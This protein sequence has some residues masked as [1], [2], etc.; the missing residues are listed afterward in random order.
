MKNK[1]LKGAFLFYVLFSSFCA[2]AQNY[3]WQWALNGGGS[4]GSGGWSYSVEQVYDIAVDTDNNYYFVA[5]IGNGSPKL[6]GSAV[7]VYNS[8]GGN[9][10]SDIFLFSTTCDGTVRWKQAIGGGA[11]DRSFKITLDNN[12]G[13]YLSARV[14]NIV[15][16]GQNVHFSPDVQMI[17]VPPYNP[18]DPQ[19]TQPSDAYKTAFVLKYNKSNGHYVQ[20]ADI[21]GNVGLPNRNA[22]ILDVAIDSSNTLHLIVGLLNGTHLNGQVTVPAGFTNTYQYYAVKYDADLNYTGSMLLPVTGSFVEPS[23]SFTYDEVKNRYYVA[24]FRSYVNVDENIPLSYN[25]VSINS[26]AYVLALN[27]ANGNEVWRREIEGTG[28]ANDI[29]IYDLELDDNG[30]VYIG[31]KFFKPFSGTVKLIDPL[32][33]A[34]TPYTYTTTVTGNMPFITKLN[35]NGIVQWSRTPTGYNWN[36][37]DTGQYYAHDIAIRN[38]EIALATMGSN[39]IWDNFQV[40]RPAGHLSDPLLIR[41]N[42]QTGTVIGMHDIMGSTGALN[43]LTA[44]DVDNDGNYIVAGAFLGSL[45]TDNVNDVAALISSGHYDF[46]A[47]K[48]GATPCGTSVSTPDFNKLSVNIYP[49]P[50]TALLYIDTEE[51]LHNYE[52]YNMLGQQLKKG[53]F[54]G[55]TQLNLQ[56]LPD[57][58]YFLK[59][60]TKQGNTATVKVIK[61]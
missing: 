24:G 52:L 44:V 60:T 47:A 57:A 32:N 49:N 7:T 18:D 40:T 11:T 2:K 1:I 35:S 50:T 5:M 56:N 27:A 26:N 36:G 3:Q 53:T 25:T 22:Q 46:F 14:S 54:E 9:G 4:L 17:S 6:D 30:D 45:F 43:M 59:L 20:K 41:F 13:I 61:K 42:K 58:A 33:T 16:N 15:G 19:G 55:T 29:R 34:T 12:N 10:N 38:N 37:A 48:L 51:T 23:F 28:G 8:S 39:T 31:G 21:Q